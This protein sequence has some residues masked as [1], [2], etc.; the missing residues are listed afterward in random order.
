MA[1]PDYI[2]F[3]EVGPV[4]KTSEAMKNK[5]ECNP[6]SIPSALKQMAYYHVF[7]PLSM[8][9]NNAMN[10]I[11]NDIGDLY[12]KKKT[13]PSAGKYTL[14]PDAFPGEDML[15]KQ[16][17][18]QAHRNWLKLLSSIAKTEVYAGWQDHHDLMANDPLF[19]SSF[20]AWKA[21]D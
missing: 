19:S 18:F 8:L 3:S 16:I 15:T 7:I 12:T 6:K 14:N 4:F 11:H 13:R 2:D 20:E 9:T 10:T 17:F 1:K 5:H 21:H